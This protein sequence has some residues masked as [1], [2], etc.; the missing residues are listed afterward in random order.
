M[1]AELF[2]VFQVICPR[3]G[4]VVGTTR[5]FESAAEV[6]DDHIAFVHSDHADTLTAD[7]KDDSSIN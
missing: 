7:V 2:G 3:C 1:T 4:A 6:I 5:S